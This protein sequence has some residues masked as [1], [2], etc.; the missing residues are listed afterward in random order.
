MNSSTSSPARTS[1]FAITSL[2]LGLLSLVVGV[3]GVL[4]GAASILFG[5]IAYRRIRQDPTLRGRRVAIAGMIIASIAV[6]IAINIY[7]WKAIWDQT[8]ESTSHLA[9]PHHL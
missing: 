6:V 2:V 8:P 4:T 7:D 5:L 1:G 9:G 3:F